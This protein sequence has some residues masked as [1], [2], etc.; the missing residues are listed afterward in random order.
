MKKYEDTCEILGVTRDEIDEVILNKS[1]YYYSYPI[2]KKNGKKRYIDAPIGKLKI[3]QNLIIKKV[4]YRFGPHSIAY[5]FAKKRNPI[6]AAEKH[7]GADILIAL[8]IKNFFN[9]ITKERV[10]EL[11]H[12]LHR[13]KPI[14][15]QEEAG[16][17]GFISTSMLPDKKKKLDQSI[18]DLAELLTYKGIV[19]Q[20]APTS[21]ALSNLFMLRPDKALSEEAK[22]L[23]ATVTRYAD[24][25]V[26]STKENIDIAGTVII[27][28]KRVLRRYGLRLNPK[29]IHI[30]RK[31]KRM[32]V[33]GII[34]NEKTNIARQNWRNF[35]ALLHNLKVSQT[36]L[37]E[38]KAQQL[39]GQIEWIKTVNPKR[40]EQFL[41]E[42]GQL[43]FMT[44]SNILT[45]IPT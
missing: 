27:F 36:P 45:S 44:T 1:S 4:L 28:T 37:N 13:S 2:R 34:V 42:Y 32:Q 9:S 38:R 15:K 26:F 17:A 39:R 20:G 3:W 19:P 25:I 18:D 14:W 23:K 40:G 43:N 33:V 41:K 5:G 11:L 22:K 29:K 24:D 6:K 10:I 7:V 35:R 21:P 16:K 31:N 8:D 30:N 12:F